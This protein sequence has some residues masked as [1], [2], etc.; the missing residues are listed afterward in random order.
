MFNNLSHRPFPNSVLGRPT[1]KSVSPATSDNQPSE[2]RGFRESL[3]WLEA[4][5]CSRHSLFVDLLDVLR[6]TSLLY[7]LSRSTAY[8]SEFHRWIGR[9]DADECSHHPHRS[10]ENEAASAEYEG[11]HL[12]NAAV[13]STDRRRARTVPRA[14]AACDS[15]DASDVDNDD[16]L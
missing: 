2:S 8:H 4:S 1:P 13:H 9:W 15:D 5:S 10:C 6:A 16:Y 3:P 14:D 11:E 7:K 12:A